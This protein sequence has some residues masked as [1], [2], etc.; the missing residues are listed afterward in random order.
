VAIEPDDGRAGT[1]LGRA[2]LLAALSLAI[3]LG[4]GQPM[5]HMLRSSLI[6]TRLADRLGLG[7][8]QR[9]VVYYANLVAWIGCHADSHELA[10]WFGDDIAFRAD[11]YRVDWAG[12]PFLGL[13][14]RHVGRDRPLLARGG[15]AVSFLA[16]PRGRVSELIHSHCASAGLLA[17]RVGL[18]AGVREALAYSFERWDGG[19]LPASVRGD[20]IPVEMR[21]VHLADVA[22]VHLRL[23]GLDG[24]VRMARDRSGTQFDPAVVATFVR[25][26]GEILGGLAGD[27]WHASLAQAPDRDRL[28]TEGELDDLLEAIG[29]FVDLKCPFTLGHSRGVAA[30]A[31]EAGRCAGLPEPDVKLLCR[32]GLVHDLGRM[33]TSNAIWE[34]PGPLSAGEWERVRLH[35]YLTGRILNRVHGLEPVAALAAAHHE[36]QDGSG[37]PRGMRGGALTPPERLLAAADAYHA[38]VEPRPHRPALSEGEAAE[39]LR[40]EAKQSRLDALAVDAVLDAAGHRIPRR[41]V[42]PAGLTTREVEVLRLVAQGRSN[43]GIAADLHISEKT[44]RNH[45]EHVYSKLGVSNR[46]G[47]SL[48]A[49]DHGIVGSFPRP[50]DER[51]G[52]R[53]MP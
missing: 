30:L 48:F 12:M 40:R 19:G 50:T 37:Y 36:R 35:P 31:A 14:L 1:G 21:V 43:R 17:D 6:A 23:G 5:E 9:G 32:A 7:E 42:W 3:D 8:Q 34:K 33:G 49:V 44:V 15:R 11:S 51:W 47:A 20:A 4:L 38:L 10:G 25:G 26:A 28:L 46:T 29:D 13:L 53:P 52:G 2:E 22:E 45:V 18:A 27:V 24:A 39:R 16:D 41:K